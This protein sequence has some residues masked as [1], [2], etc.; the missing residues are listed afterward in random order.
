MICQVP[1]ESAVAKD[2]VLLVGVFFVNETAMKK[3]IANITMANG[4][5]DAARSHPNLVIIVDADS[6]NINAMAP[7]V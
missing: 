3:G 4:V 1:T 2:R 6:C 7:T 5:I